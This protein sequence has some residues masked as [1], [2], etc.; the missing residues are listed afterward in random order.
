VRHGDYPDRTS[1]DLGAVTL[2]SG[3]ADFSKLE[4]M[5]KRIEEVT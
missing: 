2:V 3:V 1:T 4:R 5:R